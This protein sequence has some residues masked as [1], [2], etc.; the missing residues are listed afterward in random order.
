[1]AYCLKR[2]LTEGNSSGQESQWVVAADG[3]ALDCT[4]ER[5]HY[6]KIGFMVAQRVIREALAFGFL[7][8]SGVCVFCQAHVTFQNSR[9]TPVATNSI[10][11]GPSS[12]LILGPFGTAY[13][14]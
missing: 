3:I 10:V 12:G 8:G 13:Y 5:L 9:F 1:M 4:E 7:L 2:N 6:V 14:F 11:G